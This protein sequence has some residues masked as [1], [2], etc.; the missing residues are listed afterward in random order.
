ME[1]MN[2]VT[3]NMMAL[4]A[5]NDNYIWFLH[6]GRSAVVVDPGD[7][8]PVL[9]ALETHRLQLEAILVTHH[10]R[11][12][13]GGIEALRPHL[14]GTVYAPVSSKILGCCERVKNG[15]IVHCLELS[16]E[17]M[18][19]PG[20]TLDHIAYYQAASPRT[21]GKGRVF[22]GDT[23]FSAGC[24]FLFE[25]T[26]AQMLASL[27][28]L[29]A[30]PETTEV[31]C[32]HEYTLKNL[33]FAAAVEPKNHRIETEKNRCFALRQASQPTLPSTIGKERLI[34]PFLRTAEPDVVSAAL[35]QGASSTASEAV[36]AALRE[37]K[38]HF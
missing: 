12:H 24:G 35:R 26:P 1:G 14:V 23:L 32:T 13:T 17:V 31:C 19:V 28:R 18:E 16:F 29:N 34:N 25:G 10:H 4:P 20:H 21:D 33:A 9:K 30:L 38:N 15:D 8:A 5:L 2:T 22:C 37:W 6:N 3:V 11:D 36:F 7:A 27:H